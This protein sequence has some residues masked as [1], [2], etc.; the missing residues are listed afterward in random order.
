MPDVLWLLHRRALSPFSPATRC[1]LQQHLSI[2]LTMRRLLCCAV[3]P[4]LCCPR[5]IEAFH[6]IPTVTGPGKTAVRLMLR[7]NCRL[8]ASL[9]PIQY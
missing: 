9:A 3:L 4:S 2:Q 1:R 5:E 8:L 7:D 6:A